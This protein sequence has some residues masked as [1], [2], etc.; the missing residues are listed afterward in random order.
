MRG[1]AIPLDQRA[2]LTAL[3]PTLDDYKAL[4]FFCDMSAGSVLELHDTF[5]HRHAQHV[6]GVSGMGSV[7]SIR[8][9]YFRGLGAWTGFLTGVPSLL[10]TYK[11][12]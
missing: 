2:A 3:K 7:V 4:V 6:C 1:L 11:A 8:G 10:N 9:C 12:I 5:R